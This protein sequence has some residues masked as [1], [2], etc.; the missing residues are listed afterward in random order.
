MLKEFKFI[1]QSI[2]IEVEDDKIVGE[3]MTDP[4]AVY[5]TEGLHKFITSFQIKLDELNDE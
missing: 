4:T 2:F 5:G 1:V 3:H